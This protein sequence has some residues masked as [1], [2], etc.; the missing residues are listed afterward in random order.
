LNVA[1]LQLPGLRA[2]RCRAPVHRD[3]ARDRRG[4]R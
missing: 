4:C 2:G 3:P 1:F